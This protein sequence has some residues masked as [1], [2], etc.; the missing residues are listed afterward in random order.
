[1]SNH[2]TMKAA[3][4]AAVVALGIALSACGQSGD[5]QN[6]SG[7]QQPTQEQG[8]GMTQG[9]MSDQGSG[10][11]QSGAGGMNGQQDQSGAQQGGGSASGQ[12]Q[13]A[14]PQGDT[15]GDTGS[16]TQNQ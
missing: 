2:K 8:S 1:M 9:S 15:G 16:A 14:Q 6:Q 10:T 11:D 5:D 7:A 4:V 12:D 13:N 3:A